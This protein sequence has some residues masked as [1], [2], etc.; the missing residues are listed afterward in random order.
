MVNTFLTHPDFRKS[1]SRLD[2]ARL[3]KQRVEAQQILNIL[4]DLKY[5]AN[6]FDVK[7]PVKNDGDLI[8]KF[9]STLRQKYKEHPNQFL[10]RNEIPED[11]LKKGERR[12]DIIEVVKKSVTK[13][14]KFREWKVDMIKGKVY[15][16]HTIK[17]GWKT[18]HLDKV[19]LPC[20][21]LVSNGF[22]SHPAVLMWFGYESS[23]KLYINAHIDEWLYRGYNNTIKY[24]KTMKVIKRPDWCDDEQFHINHK[25]SLLKKFPEWYG[26]IFDADAIPEFVDYLW[27][28]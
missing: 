28:V 25:A 3:G 11:C 18:Y 21:R 12:V 16:L 14:S 19:I 7:V 20:D 5:L 6:Y 4:V 24:H 9:I 8:R 26:E 27:P 15:V 17:E 1:A 23:L 2:R 22:W 10:Y 13:I